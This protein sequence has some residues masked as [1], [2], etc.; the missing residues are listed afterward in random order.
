MGECK[1]LI[2]LDILVLQNSALCQLWVICVNSP[3]VPHLLDLSYFC[4]YIPSQ[5]YEHPTAQVCCYITFLFTI[6]LKCKA[7]TLHPH[8]SNSCVPYMMTHIVRH[9]DPRN[10]D[11]VLENSTIYLVPGEQFL[12][13]SST[14][15][16]LSPMDLGYEFMTHMHS[17]SQSQL[18]LWFSSM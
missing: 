6:T 12:L 1:D 2:V 8:S 7:I 10:S 9:Y 15:G 14:T 18:H 4:P 5:Q 17:Q 3:S 13:V 16:V 11:L